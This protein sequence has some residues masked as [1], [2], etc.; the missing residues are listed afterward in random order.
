MYQ[1]ISPITSLPMSIFTVEIL[2]IQYLEIMSF[3]F[4]TT[5]EM[6]PGIFLPPAPSL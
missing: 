1:S 4:M 5:G 6:E 3:D 2:L